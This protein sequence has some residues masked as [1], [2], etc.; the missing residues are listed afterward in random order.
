MVGEAD[1]G[2]DAIVG[3]RETQP[4]VVII[5]IAMPEMNGID[6]AQQIG[7]ENPQVH[8]VMLSMYSSTEH[9]FRSSRW[10]PGL[11]AQGQRGH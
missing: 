8:M 5:D 9:I 10:V 4:D 2:R 1:N 3:V 7:E 11:P 6:T